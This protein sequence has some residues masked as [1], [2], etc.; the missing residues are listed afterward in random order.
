MNNIWHPWDTLMK[1]LMRK[2]AQALASLVL[3]GIVLGNA[4]D[5]ELKVKNI[6]ADFFFEAYLNGLAIILHLEFQRNRDAGMDR[7]MWEY[8]ATMDINTGK[9]VYSIVVYLV[10]EE[11]LVGSPYIR[12]IPGT[13]AGHHF[14]FQ[15]IKLWE[16]PANVLKRTEFEALLPL[17]PLTQ[18]GK[19]LDTV[20][21]MINELQARNRPDLLTLGYNFAGLVFTDEVDQQ[22]LKERFHKM[23]DI[24]EGSWVYQEMTAKSREEGR[25]EGLE[26]GR[27][28]GLE[29]GRQQALQQAAI[30]IVAAR[31]PALEQLTRAII[32]TISD[33][34]QLQ[35]L[36]VELST[37]SSQEQTKQLLLSLVSAA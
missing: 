20:E 27:E 32:A 6:E 21:D 33:P 37:S 10:E 15:V 12:E 2:E 18:A 4:L 30:S 34:N 14:V 31:F 36:I 25:E 29:K 7:R 5:K 19:S 3:P 11:N 1:L 8:N 16:I 9:P 13:G 28:E 23:Q 35:V 22:W 24:M 26:K 17:L